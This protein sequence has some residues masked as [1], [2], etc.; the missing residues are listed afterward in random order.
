MLTLQRSASR[1]PL[2]SDATHSPDRGSQY[3]PPQSASLLQRG[4]QVGTSRKHVPS[5][6]SPTSHSPTSLHGTPV[7]IQLGVHAKSVRPW[8]FAA[9]NAPGREDP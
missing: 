3:S 7:L 8:H 5:Q 1:R 9:S 6:R 4:M 2:G